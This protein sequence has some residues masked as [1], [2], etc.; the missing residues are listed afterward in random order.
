MNEEEID[1]V[2]R[3][4]IGAIKRFDSNYILLTGDNDDIVLPVALV[5]SGYT[6][7]PITPRRSEDELIVAP[8]YF[9]Y[10][11]I[12]LLPEMDDLDEEA[13]SDVLDLI[14]SITDERFQQ[15]SF[16]K[17]H[18]VNVLVIVIDTQHTHISGSSVLGFYNTKLG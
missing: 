12:T 3:S 6:G 9:A 8:G 13:H 2:S 10:P 17:F 4:V 7:L 16:E 1:I 11:G 14:M 5:V 18:K 15:P